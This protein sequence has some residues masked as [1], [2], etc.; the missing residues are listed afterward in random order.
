MLN[1]LSGQLTQVQ[2][3]HYQAFWYGTLSFMLNGFWPRALAV[4]FLALSMWFAFLRRNIQA[5]IYSFVV[6]L[7]FVYGGPLLHWFGLL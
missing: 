7:C 3:A 2:A 6:M 1:P 4:A 5:S